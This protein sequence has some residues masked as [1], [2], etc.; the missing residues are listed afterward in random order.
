MTKDGWRWIVDAHK[1]DGKG[2]IVRSDEL[3]E[4]VSGIG[5][6]VTVTLLRSYSANCLSILSRVNA[7]LAPCLDLRLAYNANDHY[8]QH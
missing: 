8:E 5:S 7:W 6:D 3:L 2:Y 1:G 4:R